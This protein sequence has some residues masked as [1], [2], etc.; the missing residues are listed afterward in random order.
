MDAAGPP[1]IG[2]PWFESEPE[3]DEFPLLLLCPWLD[4]AVLAPLEEVS[5][6]LE[7]DEEV[8]EGVAEGVN[9]ERKTLFTLS[10]MDSAAGAAEFCA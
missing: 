5:V 1:E 2:E 10:K 8:G 7:G 6:D 3:S 9:V 4:P